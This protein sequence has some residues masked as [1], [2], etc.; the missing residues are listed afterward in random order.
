M[1]EIFLFHVGS[2]LKAIERMR[3]FKAYEETNKAYV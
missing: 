1:L 3:Y 2:V